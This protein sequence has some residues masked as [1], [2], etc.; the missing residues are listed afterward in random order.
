MRFVHE[1]VETLPK[2]KMKMF[3]YFFTAVF[4]TS[5][6]LNVD[7]SFEMRLYGA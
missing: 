1:A 3:S 2:K 6:W 7:I 5:N 4:L